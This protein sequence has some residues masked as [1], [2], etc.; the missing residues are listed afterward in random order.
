MQT[1]IHTSFS[2]AVLRA[3]I[4]SAN[5]ADNTDDETMI[6]TRGATVTHTDSSRNAVDEIKLRSIRRDDVV[7]PEDVQVN[8]RHAAQHELRLCL[9]V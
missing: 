5:T 2:V 6:R 7:V 3:S 1:H 8:G 4:P 9:T